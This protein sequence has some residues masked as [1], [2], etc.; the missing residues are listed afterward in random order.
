M[1]GAFLTDVSIAWT[2]AIKRALGAL[3]PLGR[4]GK[5]KEIVGA[6][7]YFSSDAS[8]YTSGAIAKINGGTVFGR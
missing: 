5:P 6:A 7:L 1:P 4:V 2:E 3:A 8:L